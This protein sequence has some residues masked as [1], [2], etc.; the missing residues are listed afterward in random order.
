MKKFLAIASVLTCLFFNAKSQQL[1]KKNLDKVV[2]VLGSNIILLSELN[3]Q[4]AQH[5]NQGNPA[6][7]SFKC[8][9]LR[10]M[11]GNKLLKLQAEIDSV[12]VE[13]AQVDDEVDK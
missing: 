9:I 2:A 6:N 10:D 4:Y 11:L 5:L 1:P 12:Y 8:L 3:Q 13:E 7:E